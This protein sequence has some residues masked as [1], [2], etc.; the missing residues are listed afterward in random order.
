MKHCSREVEGRIDQGERDG[1]CIV[2]CIAMDGF[3]QYL[4]FSTT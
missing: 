1:D 2:D 4:D 3:R